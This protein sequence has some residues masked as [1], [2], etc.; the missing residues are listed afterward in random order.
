MSLLDSTIGI[1]DDQV[2]EAWIRQHMGE[3]TIVTQN[4][5]YSFR[6]YGD[7]LPFYARRDSHKI[8]VVDGVIYSQS[9]LDTAG[10]TDDDYQKWQFQSQLTLNLPEGKLPNIRFINWGTLYIYTESEVL[11]MT[12]FPTHIY[13][14]LHIVGPYLKR[15]INNPVQYIRQEHSQS[16]A[17]LKI[18]AYNLRE[19]DLRGMKEIQQISINAACLETI[20]ADVDYI[21]KVGVGIHTI[22]NSPLFRD[23]DCQLHLKIHSVFREMG[24]RVGESHINE[25]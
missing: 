16:T 5:G 7:E 18:D 6:K 3:I 9:A 15:L 10:Y 13:G 2:A 23:L 11:D 25:N 12:G 8:R 20:K 4:G 21:K 17:W 22:E 1:S 24:I 19:L 14:C